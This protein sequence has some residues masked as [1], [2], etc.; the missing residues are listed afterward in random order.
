ME[1]GSSKTLGPKLGVSMVSFTWLQEILVVSL[2]MVIKPF[3][4][5]LHK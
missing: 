3:E 4:D 2:N 5:Y 1:F